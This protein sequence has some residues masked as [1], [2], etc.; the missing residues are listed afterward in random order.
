MKRRILA[1]GSSEMKLK[2]DISRFPVADETI[3]DENAKGYRFVP[4]GTGASSALAVARL[5]GEAVI[6][7]AVGGDMFGGVLRSVLQRDGV[8]LRFF[9]TSKTSPTALTADMDISGRNRVLK[10]RAAA[11]E[12]TPLDVE[13]AMLCRPDAMLVSADLP[14]STVV[15]V[16]EYAAARRISAVLDASAE[17][18]GLPFSSLPPLEIFCA[19]G[20]LVE[21]LTGIAPSDPEACLRAS[22]ALAKKV[23]AKLYVMRLGERGCYVYDGKYYFCIPSY[24]AGGG[25]HR[26]EPA[27]VFSAAFLLEYLRSHGNVTRAGKYANI[28]VSLSASRGGGLLSVPY[29]ADVMRFASDIGMAL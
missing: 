28:A 21:A 26:G 7:S 12:L 25:P 13:G 8:D 19:S 15:T 2:M 10:Y 4:S 6:L 20:S 11:E 17:N 27:P 1:V 29:E 14:A 18:V 24:Y 23:S 3:Y 5:G 16:L 9:V 22:V